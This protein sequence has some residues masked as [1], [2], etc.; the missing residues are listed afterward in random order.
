MTPLQI[1]FATLAAVTAISGIAIPLWRASHRYRIRWAILKPRSMTEVADEIAG[2]LSIQ[3]QGRPIIGVTR[4]QFVLHNTGQEPLETG[5]IVEPLRWTGPGAILSAR[6]AKTQPPVALTLNVDGRSV[7]ISWSLFNPRCMALLDILCECRGAA[8]KGSLHGQI[9]RVTSLEV[10]EISILDL[11][12]AVRRMRLTSELT[13]PRY[14]KFM[15]RLVVN[16]WFLRINQWLL[17]I[18]AGAVPIYVTW[19]MV[20]DGE[21]PGIALAAVI[22][23]VIVIFGLLWMYLRNPY[24]HLV[25]RTRPVEARPL[26]GA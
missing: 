18:Y 8:D 9:R 22:P 1:A 6:V 17:P 3:F 16:R 4:F 13:T 23:V 24:A 7:Q 12:E 25:E 21:L 11:D 20:A 26:V 19:I 10:K 2:E 5:D 14:M 15:N